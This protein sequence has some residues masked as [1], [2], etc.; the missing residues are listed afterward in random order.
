MGSFKTIFFTAV[1]LIQIVIYS[2]AV[3]RI[4]EGT[5][6][7]T[8]NYSNTPAEPLRKKSPG[9]METKYDAIIEKYA[10]ASAIDP[11]LVKCIIKVESDFNPDA[12]SVA[13]AGGLMQLLQETARD[14]G[15]EDRTD[16]EGNIRAGVSHFSWLMKEFKGEI[17]LALAAYHAGIGRV[18]RAGSVPPIKSTVDYVND[19]MSLYAGGGDY[20]Q[21]VRKLYMKIGKDGTIRI[22]D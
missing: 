8:A 14:L 5:S 1:I 3:A 22:S 9:R 18:K 4:I 16:P 2:G 13:G 15:L 21:V 19:V 6:G 11:Y 20:S 12:V 7:D 10:G 17:P